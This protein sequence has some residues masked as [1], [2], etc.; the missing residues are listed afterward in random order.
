MKSEFEV[1]LRLLQHESYKLARLSHKL[2][3][4]QNSKLISTLLSTSFSLDDI[5]LQAEEVREE[6]VAREQR[7]R[8]GL[9]KIDEVLLA[10]S[11]IKQVCDLLLTSDDPPGFEDDEEKGEVQ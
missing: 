2:S 4:G 1:Y 7:L 11:Q 3:P 6:L 8:E 10:A 9:Q 5:V